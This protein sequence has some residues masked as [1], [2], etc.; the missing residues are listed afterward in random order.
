MSRE[1]EYR[2][3]RE[4][5]LDEMIGNIDAAITSALAV[6]LAVALVGMVVLACW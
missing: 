4:K 3:Q 1:D 2:R 6:L 5:R